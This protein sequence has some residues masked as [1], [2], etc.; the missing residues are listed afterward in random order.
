M[1]SRLGASLANA[2]KH[3]ALS[4]RSAV[5]PSSLRAFCSA[6]TTQEGLATAATEKTASADQN[7]G[8]AAPESAEATQE[9]HAF[10]PFLHGRMG[11][12]VVFGK[13]TGSG[14]YMLKSD[15]VH[16]LEGCNLTVEDVKVDYNRAYNSTGM[17]VQFSSLSAYETAIKQIARNGR[18]YKL[19]KVNQAQWDL[20]ETYN[21]KV[22][23]MLN[24]PRNALIEDIERFLCGC[25]YDG[26]DIKI[27]VRPNET[28]AALVRFPSQAEAMHAVRV[29]NHTFCLNSTVQMHVLQ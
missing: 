23:L 10:D 16:F 3:S 18:L 2:L 4:P 14:R 24:I 11:T 19:E 29:K 28:K 9:E 15:V 13:M 22:V 20:Q 26:S 5:R 6:A 12:G 27:S 17:L 25:N 8:E 21:G 1:A 7:A